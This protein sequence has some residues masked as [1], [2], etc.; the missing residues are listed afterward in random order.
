MSDADANERR[1][2]TIQLQPALSPSLDC[3]ATI[4]SL[5]SLSKDSW[6]NGGNDDGPYVN[7]FLRTDDLAKLWNQIQTVLLADVEV[8][9]CAIVTCEGR[10]GWD[11]YLLLHHFDGSQPLDT[12][13]N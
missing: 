5:T 3:R 7:V 2:I 10:Q 8:A 6:F 13:S 1:T 12:I 11:D 9:K 4:Q